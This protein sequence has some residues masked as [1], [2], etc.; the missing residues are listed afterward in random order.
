[1]L[2]YSTYFVVVV[3]LQS[4]IPV[5]VEP[6]PHKHR[7]GDLEMGSTDTLSLWRE[8]L[9]GIVGDPNSNTDG[10]IPS[11]SLVLPTMVHARQLSLPPSFASQHQADTPCRQST[12]PSLPHN[13][14]R[15]SLSHPPVPNRHHSLPAFKHSDRPLFPLSI[16]AP[17]A[18]SVFHPQTPSS[19]S[20]S[21]PSS[22]NPQSQSFSSRSSAADPQSSKGS[23]RHLSM[24]PLS[25]PSI[26]MQSTRGSD[27]RRAKLSKPLPAHLL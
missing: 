5:V 8:K 16:S 13:N 9:K 4:R 24:M 12:M 10:S 14:Q 18:T 7:S 27:P 6:R 20:Y 1:M 2:S 17:S 22:A 21:T 15:P 11:R 19:Y 26:E 3:Y 25:S 23:S